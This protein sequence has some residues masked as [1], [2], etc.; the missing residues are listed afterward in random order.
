MFADV[1]FELITGDPW[2]RRSAGKEA[3]LKGR[4]F[5]S[6][7]FPVF[8]FGL[9]RLTGLRSISLRDLLV[10]SGVFAV[11]MAF[12]PDPLVFVSVFMGIV[13]YVMWVV[14]KET[15]SQAPP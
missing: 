5:Q 10:F 7:T 13:Y 2:F 4:I 8:A 12:A 9:Y 14:D 11:T 1:C 6:L 15:T 3:S